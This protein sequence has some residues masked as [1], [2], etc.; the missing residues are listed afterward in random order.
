MKHI[1]AFAV[2]WLALFGAIYFSVASYNTC[3][4]ELSKS[5]KNYTLSEIKQ[6]CWK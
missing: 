2:F 6:T 5:E 3:V 1:N 4:V